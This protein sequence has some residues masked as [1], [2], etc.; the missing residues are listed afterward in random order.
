MFPHGPPKQQN[1]A[2]IFTSAHGVRAPQQAGEWPPAADD[3]AW[4]SDLTPEAALLHLFITVQQGMNPFL[5]PIY[6]QLS[7]STTVRN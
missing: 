5:F 4:N 7:N 3:A 2:L 1:V 6:Q